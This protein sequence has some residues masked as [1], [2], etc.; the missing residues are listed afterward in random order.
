[1]S[2]IEEL[3]EAENLAKAFKA[4]LGSAKRRRPGGRF[5]Q[6]REIQNDFQFDPVRTVLFYRD[7]W[8]HDPHLTFSR[9]MIGIPK[10]KGG[11][12]E[13]PISIFSLEQRVLC[14]AVLNVIWAPLEKEIL[15][16]VSYCTFRKDGIHRPRGVAEAVTRL[17][18]ARIQSRT[19]VLESDI[20]GF[21][22]AI[23]RDRLM[24]ILSAILPDDTLAPLLRSIVF[25]ETTVDM[26]TM[27][28]I[29]FDQ[30]CG[31]PQ[32]AAIS[33]LLA[34]SYLKS[35][36]SA[37]ASHGIEII[38]YVDDFVVLLADNAEFE[39]V[40]ARVRDLLGSLDLS[41]KPGKTFQKQPEDEIE[42]LGHR[43]TSSNRILLRQKRWD[44][45]AR[46]IAS[47]VSNIPSEGAES[48]GKAIGSY[49]TGF[50]KNTSH[51][52]WD[53]KT[54]REIA[55]MI[56][57]AAKARCVGHRALTSKILAAKNLPLGFLSE[58]GK[59]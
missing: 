18:E 16:H 19:F 40:E 21:F 46:K 37:I 23:N 49:L 42:F 45:V 9:V 27:K 31:V 14:R 11:R 47:E 20:Q 13:R 29:A 24:E 10:K 7:K 39:P 55:L 4:V 25:A 17:R 53:T 1:M 58:L 44:E 30:D 5:Q 41:M 51:C 32:G 35:F 43:I 57:R 56:P 15:P 33:P 8:L 52:D 3:F 26:R 54:Y 6:T 22:D 2:L 38:R 50:F 36:D 59:L 34:C 12:P 28:G 48:A